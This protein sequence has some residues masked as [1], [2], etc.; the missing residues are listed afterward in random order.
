MFQAGQNLTEVSTSNTLS[1]FRDVG[2]S[3]QLFSQATNLGPQNIEP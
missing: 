1:N 2:S 3:D